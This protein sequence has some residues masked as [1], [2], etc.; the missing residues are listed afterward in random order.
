[1]LSAK[2][3]TF[4]ENL[5]LYLM[6]SGKKEKEV[7]ELTEELKLHLIESEKQGKNIEEIIDCSPEHYMNS[8]KNEMDTDYK[9]LAKNLPI[10]FAGV[11]AYFL[12]G[13]ALRDEFALNTVQVI[14]F[15]IITIIVLTIYV[16]F[17][18]QAGKKQF[19]TKNFFLIGVIASASVTGL[20]ILLLLGSGLFVEPF[21]IGSTTVNW[22]IVSA[23]SSIFILLAVWSKSWLSIWIPAI[24]FIPDL[25]FRF[26]N[27]TDETILVVSMASFIL[28]FIIMILGLLFKERAKS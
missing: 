14:G 25:L 5:R 12:M 15:P 17:L 21:Y 3:E 20:F 23:C 10:F 26:S 11:M 27:L 4:I 8:L 2:S 22:I 9:S 13:P 16:F 6:T 28:L 18:Q 1:M 19:S 7:N 24:L